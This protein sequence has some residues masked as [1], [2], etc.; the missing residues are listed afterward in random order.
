M[1][2]LV[3]TNIFVAYHSRRSMLSTAVMAE[4]VKIDTASVWFI[5]SADGCLDAASRRDMRA[6]GS[7]YFEATTFWGN[8]GRYYDAR[9]VSRKIL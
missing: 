9:W 4:Q 8:R 5:T 7:D 2:K 6:I 1:S 3:S